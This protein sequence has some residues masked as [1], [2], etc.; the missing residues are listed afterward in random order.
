[1]YEGSVKVLRL[2]SKA[3]SRYYGSIAGLDPSPHAGN[4]DG[5]AKV[6]HSAQRN[7]WHCSQR[8]Q[9]EGRSTTKK[10]KKKVGSTSRM[11]VR[12]RHMPTRMQRLMRVVMRRGGAVGVE[13]GRRSL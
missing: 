7:S 6:R 8:K 1:M 13:V 4:S 10:S 9:S 5:T 2:Y 12:R 11:I 3:L